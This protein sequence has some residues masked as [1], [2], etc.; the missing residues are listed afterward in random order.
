MAHNHST[1]CFDRSLW[2]SEQNKT[3]NYIPFLSG[4]AVHNFYWKKW[5]WRLKFT[6]FG[7]EC[8]SQIRGIR[9]SV[10]LGLMEKRILITSPQIS[11]SSRSLITKLIKLNSYEMLSPKNNRY[12]WSFGAGFF[13]QR[14]I[15]HS[16]GQTINAEYYEIM[17]N[18]LRPHLIPI[19]DTI[20]KAE[21]LKDFH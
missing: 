6:I 18:H 14:A 3:V 12:H 19:P 16:W 17:I 5:A 21:V 15:V 2:I 7:W 11:V 13:K 20:F 4:Q 1:L 8:A 9:L 10:G